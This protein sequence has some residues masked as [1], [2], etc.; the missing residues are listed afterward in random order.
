MS[1]PDN[2][3]ETEP[4][5]RSPAK[6]ANGAS[7][8]AQNH[9][10]PG[11]IAAVLR[12]LFVLAALA[13]LLLV[14]LPNGYRAIWF[15][16]LSDMV[17][18]PLFAIITFLL[19]RFC[20]PNWRLTV[21]V[22]AFLLAAGA[23]VVQPLFGRSASWR[24]LA[25]DTVGIAIAMV[26][27][28]RQ[29]PL[30]WRSALVAALLM[31]PLAHVGPVLLDGYRAWRSFP[32]LADFD[33]PFCDRRWLR[34]RVRLQPAGG[35][36]VVEFEA[37]PEQ[38][39]G[40]ILLPVVRNWTGYQRLVIDFSFEGEPLLFLISVRDGKKLPPE[41]PRF[42]LWRH[43]Q[44]GKHH[45]EIDLE[46][47]ARGG[48][49]PPIELDRVQSLHLEAFDDQPRIMRVGPIRLEGHKPVNSGD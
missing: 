18:V 8:A 27:L 43:Y 23:E 25:Y 29:W 5:A 34:K 37:A 19:V 7:V 33:G 44:P 36:A 13:C 21:V 32:V 30:P 4:F 11:R 9:P 24:D 22:I 47:L 3:P 17:H 35:V 6:E 49:F 16:D 46:E 10:A 15:G 12:T 14:P 42:D 38:G 39:A 26:T 48:N 45:V 2:H 20:W 1:T 41:V 28:Q 40:M 31:W